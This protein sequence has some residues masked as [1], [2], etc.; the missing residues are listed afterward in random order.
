MQSKREKII[1]KTIR[2]NKLWKNWTVHNLVSHPAS[3]IVYWVSIPF[4]GREKAESISGWVH[5][6]TIPDH[7]RE[8]QVENE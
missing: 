2:M 1:L 6:V 7:V 4:V 3:E 5:D 8:E